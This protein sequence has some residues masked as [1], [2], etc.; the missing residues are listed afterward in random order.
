MTDTQRPED[1]D[2]EF[3]RLYAEV[4]SLTTRLEQATAEVERLSDGSRW[5]EDERKA[6]LFEATKASYAEGVRAGCEELSMEAARMSDELEAATTRLEQAEGAIARA[7]QRYDAQPTRDE[8][9]LAWAMAS[10]LRALSTTE[11][12][13]DGRMYD[14][15]PHIETATEP[16][17]DLHPPIPPPLPTPRPWSGS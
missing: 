14:R 13:K 6:F 15:C 10:D 8:T 7:V 3:N 2:A 11:P 16:C 1:I 5:T 12:S 17:C 9:G 4:A